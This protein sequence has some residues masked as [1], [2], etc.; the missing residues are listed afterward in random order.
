MSCALF[1]PTPTN[2]VASHREQYVPNPYKLHLVRCFCYKITVRFAFNLDCEHI[3]ICQQVILNSKFFS[4]LLISQSF[5]KLVRD[6]NFKV[7][8]RQR[9][10]VRKM[11]MS[12][13]ITESKQTDRRKS[14]AFTW[15]SLR[16][17]FS[18]CI[19]MHV[20][21]AICFPHYVTSSNLISNP[22]LNKAC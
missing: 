9:T 1:C 2:T 3:K 17:V 5:W 8:E 16:C 18:V 12:K 15:L 19:C 11:P 7:T 22:L 4:P 6:S 21:S 13:R 20:C 10:H 14:G